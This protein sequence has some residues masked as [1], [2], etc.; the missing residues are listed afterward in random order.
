[1]DR[2]ARLAA[3]SPGLVALDRARLLAQ[4][5]QCA[6]EALL[7]REQVAGLVAESAERLEQSQRLLA[8]LRRTLR[9]PGR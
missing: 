8:P 6:R 4:A 5:G 1:M 3:A 9:S 7:L 2:P